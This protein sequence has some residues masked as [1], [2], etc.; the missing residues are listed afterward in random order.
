VAVFSLEYLLRIVAAREKVAFILSFHAWW[1]CSRSRL[2]F[3]AGLD[4]RWLRVL[5]LL[6]LLRV[7]KLQTHILE[8]TVAERTRELADRNASLEQAQAQIKAELDVARALQIAI[9]PATFPAKPGCDGA[10]RMIPATRCVETSTT[11]SSCRT[12]GSVW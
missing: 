8:N 9:L 1:T 4:A 12:D 5:R 11:S 6:R 2:F 3:L 7:L 10:A